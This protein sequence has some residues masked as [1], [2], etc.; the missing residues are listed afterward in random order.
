MKREGE[1]RGW[2]GRRVRETRQNL[3]KTRPRQRM[4]GIGGRAK[5][6]VLGASVWQEAMGIST[7]LREKNYDICM[8]AKGHIFSK[9]ESD[10]PHTAP[11]H[12]EALRR[13]Q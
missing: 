11:S 4:K 7:S 6:H 9:F 5:G 8:A 1:K 12:S 13:L 10:L 3:A 2:V